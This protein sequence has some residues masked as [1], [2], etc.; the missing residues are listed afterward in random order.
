VTPQTIALALLV[1]SLVATR[2]WEEGRWR[3]GRMSDR[4]NALLVVGRL[5]ALALGFGLITGLDPV[6]TLGMTAIAALAA[7]VLYAP[8]VA[9]LRRTR[10]RD[11]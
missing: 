1:F 2:L 11:G 6:T 9:R 4:T 7:A 10:S 3:A 5:P 8:V